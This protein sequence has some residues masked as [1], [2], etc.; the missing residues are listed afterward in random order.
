[1]VF[2]KRVMEMQPTLQPICMTS[3]TR[4]KWT[5]KQNSFLIYEYIYIKIHQDLDQANCQFRFAMLI[6]ILCNADI[7][8]ID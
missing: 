6:L 3:T 2:G 8:D 7:A 5:N 4:K 1:M